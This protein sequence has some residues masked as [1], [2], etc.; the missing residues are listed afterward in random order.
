[1][2]VI[3]LALALL[4]NGQIMQQAIVNT[5]MTAAGPPTFVTEVSAG[6]GA[7]FVIDIASPAV[8]LTSSD[9]VL[10]SCQAAS[11][12]TTFTASNSA[13]DTVTTLTTT[14]NGAQ[15]Q[16]IA[17]FYILHPSAGAI[18]FHCHS[19]GSNQYL[20]IQLA[21]FTRGFLTAFDTSAQSI[22]ASASTSHTTPTFTTT[23]KGLI[24]AYGGGFAAA[25]GGVTL[26]N[27]GATSPSTIVNDGQQGWGYT[28]PSSSQ[29]SI[30][31]SFTSVNSVKFQTSV[32]AF[33]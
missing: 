23:A 7:T 17:G 25:S 32:L 19:S 30:T 31:A 12:S 14:H 21:V 18:T 4:L 33:K 6:S 24:A 20:S 27:I 2:K 5:P 11:S 29:S 9:I 1:M 3:L 16:G 10:G 28:L 26:G 22:E 8:T 13:S 15:V